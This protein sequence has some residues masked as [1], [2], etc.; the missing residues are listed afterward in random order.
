VIRDQPRADSLTLDRY[1]SIRALQQG[2]QPRHSIVVP[3]NE[4]PILPPLRAP[5]EPMPPP[6]PR[7]LGETPPIE[8]KK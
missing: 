3:V 8:M 5:D 6:A 7:P 1:E 2:S 4:A